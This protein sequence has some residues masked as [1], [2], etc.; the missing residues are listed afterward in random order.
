MISGKAFLPEEI[1][2]VAYLM[3]IICMAL[4]H[5]AQATPITNIQIFKVILART[6]CVVDAL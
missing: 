4:P 1:F 2:F 6:G 3:G 5:T